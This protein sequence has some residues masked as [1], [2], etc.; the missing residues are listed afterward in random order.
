MGLCVAIFLATSVLQNRAPDLYERVFSFAALHGTFDAAGA[1]DDL[2]LTPDAS[3]DVGEVNPSRPWQFV[4]YQFLHGGWMH[5]LGNM[6]IL[7]VFGPVVED[8][9]R[10]WWFLGFYLAAGAFAGLIHS[11]FELQSVTQGGVSYRIA[12]PVIGASGSIA[13]VTGAFLVLFPLSRIDIIWFLGI[14]GRFAIPAWWFIGFAIARD[15]VFQAV[16]SGGV[17]HWAHI[18]GYISGIAVAML[19][20]A[21]GWIP[22]E[23]YNLFTMTKQAHRRRAYRELVR[24]RGSAFDAEAARA[25]LAAD[26]RTSRAETQRAE[27]RAAILEALR[28]GS[29]ALAAERFAALLEDSPDEVLPRDSQL[30]LANHWFGAGRHALAAKAYESMLARYPADPERHETSLM[31]ALVCARYLNDPVRASA[32]L[33]GLDR[34]A[35]SPDHRALADTIRAEI[36]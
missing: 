32:L 20:L 33:T 28:A 6:L 36:V 21:S 25:R 11:V 4:T 29:T 14:I 31:L 16:G 3:I 17:A 8:R 34:A 22:R 10:R 1:P 7:W 19:A 2:V 18:G 12:P 24:S 13:G 35:L 27:R 30:T 9:L 23:P 26:S 5:L 15:F